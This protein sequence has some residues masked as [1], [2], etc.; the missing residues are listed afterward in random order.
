MTSG[1]AHGSNLEYQRQC[2]DVL[3]V[4]RPQLNP[5][6]LDGIDVPIDLPD[7][8]WA[9]DVALRD[10]IGK[11]GVAECRRTVGAV[12]QE[13][14]AAFAYKV[15]MLR[16][17]LE[18]DVAGVFIAKREHQIGAIK[19]GQFNGIETAVL[20][21]GAKPPAF[22]ITYLRYDTQ[23]EKRCRD[24]ALHL[25]PSSLAFTGNHATVVIR[26]GENVAPGS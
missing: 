1:H 18:I 13:D 8:C 7:T 12:K 16:K 5:W 23:R 11:L 22:N 10:P 17:F 9:F 25:P 15:E 24:V 2:R 20:E 21:E 6:A 3:L 14:V 4:R 19:V 26:K